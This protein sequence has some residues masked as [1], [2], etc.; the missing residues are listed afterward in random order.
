M[1]RAHA[2]SPDTFAHIVSEGRAPQ[3]TRGSDLT[4]YARIRNAA[5]DSFASDGVAATS[6]RHVARAADVSAGLVQHYFPT[7]TALR[8]AVDEHVIELAVDAVGDL[9][10]TTGSETD[11]QE[12]DDRIA[13]FVHE[14]PAVLRYVARSAAEGDEAAL[15]IFDAFVGIVAAQLQRLAEEDCLHPDLDLSWAALHV[16]VLNLGTVLLRAA[17]DRHLPEPFFSEEGLRRWN[18]AS[19]SLFRRGVYRSADPSGDKISR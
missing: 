16:L 8:E 18:A 19:G 2:T 3:H 17:V 15:K 5:L 14:H 13:A 9:P 7:K 10:I 4:A 6:I 1:T 11:L 12:I